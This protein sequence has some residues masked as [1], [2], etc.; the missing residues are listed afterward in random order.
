MDSSPLISVIIP[1]YNAEK[2]V[3][4]SIQSV[5]NQSYQ[6]FEIICVDD[7][8]TDNTRV[9]IEKFLGDERIKLVDSPSKGG[10]PAR[11]YG[12]KLAKGD[13]IQFLDAD[14]ILLPHKF[15]L[16]LSVFTDDV[17]LVV[18]DFEIMDED[19][20][21]TQFKSNL[22]SIEQNFLET[23]ITKII[24]TNNPL[25][26]KEIVQKIGGYEPNLKKAQDWDFHIRLALSGAR[27]A[28][29]E[30]I[31]FKNRNVKDSVSDDWVDVSIIQCKILLDNQTE[32]ASH[33]A[34]NTP[35][36]GFISQMHYNCMVHAYPDNQSIPEVMFDSF[37]FWKS[38]S[39]PITR[40]K[41]GIIAI[42]GLHFMLKMDRKRLKKSSS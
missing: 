32:I 26:R 37:S 19:L 14:D 5:L 7:G 27:P 17:D 33:K 28:F 40:L 30:G 24:I 22:C 10:N 12:L 25:Y 42:C 38:R 41:K 8:S 20:K 34:C 11:N 9:E 16:Q 36:N 35:I 4:E 15:E 18:S 29:V 39:F 6:N 23:A 3:C 31:T 2:Y 13:V 1:C 21:T